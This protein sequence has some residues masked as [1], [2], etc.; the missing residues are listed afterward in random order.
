M[1]EHP[2]LLIQSEC[3]ILCRSWHGE[4][5]VQVMALH[6]QSVITPRLPMGTGG[7]HL[8]HLM[9]LLTDVGRAV[10]QSSFRSLLS[11][12]MQSWLRVHCIQCPAIHSETTCSRQPIV[13]ATASSHET[14]ASHA[15]PGYC[16]ARVS[17]TKCEDNMSKQPRLPE[18]TPR[19]VPRQPRLQRQDCMNSMELMP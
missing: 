3:F 8:I 4:A 1:I 9:L 18:G 11:F 2:P 17:C 16:T 19:T 12:S 6:S 7:T 5:G 14:P 10:G 13:Q 15:M